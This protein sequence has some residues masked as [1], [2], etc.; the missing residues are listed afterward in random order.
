MAI[1][2]DMF[3]FASAIDEDGLPVQVESIIAILP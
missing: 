1:A 2:Q 3:V